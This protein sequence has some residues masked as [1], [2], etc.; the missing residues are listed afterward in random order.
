LH[1]ASRQLLFTNERFGGFAPQREIFIAVP[2]ELSD[3]PHFQCVH[4]RLLDRATSTLL[5]Q[6]FDG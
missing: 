4:D 3:T 6:R 1:R 2:P 5:L